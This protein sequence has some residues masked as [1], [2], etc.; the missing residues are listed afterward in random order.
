MKAE[1]TGEFALI[2][3][4]V[5]EINRVKP[6]EW[7]SVLAGPGDDAA[8][9]QL[10]GRYQIA[11]TDC[12][13]EGVHFE[14]DFLDWESLGWKA[15][16]T[17][18]SDIAAMGGTPKYALVSL[19]QPASTDFD[20][21]VKLYQGMLMLAKE[22]GTVIAGG[23]ISRA[24]ELGIHT[25]VIGVVDSPSKALLRSKAKIGDVIAVTGSLGAAAA[26][27]RT[28]YRSLGIGHSDAEALQRAFWHPQPR[29]KVG[30][31]L[32]KNGIKC[33]IDISDGF[34]ADLG[35]ILEASGVGARVEAERIPI[36]PS[37]V[38][39][40]GEEALQMALSGGEDYEL[41]F[42]GKEAAVSKVAAEAGC[43]VTVI[44]KI[45]RGAEKLNVV[46]SHGRKM[47][48]ES[49]GWQHF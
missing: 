34:L 37:V 47:R 30:Q 38:T 40:Y 45:I 9:I 32:V 15:L 46:N 48:I 10:R 7:Q 35:H 4:I 2:D 28:P 8:L 14:R 41:L 13:I 21:I 24:S 31:L 43:N 19:D 42:T 6:G 26:G 44:G 23:N 12:L 29:L 27:L 20:D 18:L 16:A 17:S 11:T 1:K 33:A 25:T 22:S 39:I 5:A 3:R 36:H 49:T